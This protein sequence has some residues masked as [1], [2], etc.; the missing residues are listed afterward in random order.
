M[1]Q[2]HSHFCQLAPLFLYLYT[3]QVSCSRYHGDTFLLKY[4][5]C[6]SE[7][8]YLWCSNLCTI[9]ELQAPYVWVCV[10]LEGIVT[11]IE[12]TQNLD[13]WTT[14]IHN[15]NSETHGHKRLK[16]LTDGC[17]HCLLKIKIKKKT[18]I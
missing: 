12:R 18:F 6:N 2:K 16:I 14:H 11:S 17:K 13:S 4:H 15:C 1:R 5:K 3:H 10:N 8:V 7:V 9:A